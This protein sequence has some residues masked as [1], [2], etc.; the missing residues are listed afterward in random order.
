MKTLRRL[1]LTLSFALVAVF[2]S[3]TAVSCDDDDDTNN[4]NNINNINNTNNPTPASL[5]VIHLS[6]DAPGVDIYV[7]GESQVVTDLMFQ[8][9]TSF[10]EVDEGT[11]DFN[12]TATQTPVDQSVLDIEGVMLMGGSAYTVAAYDALSDI[13]AMLLTEDWSE[14]GAG[15]IRVRAIH[16]AG[17]V[18]E[19][20]IWE[21]SDPEN[22]IELYPNIGFGDVGDYMDLPAG[23]YTLGIDVDND[24]VPDVK[25]EIPALPA[26]T[27]ANI[28]AV[29]EMEEVYLV[30]QFEDHTTTVIEPS[31]MAGPAH[32][33][34]LHLSPDAPSVDVFVDGG[35]AFENIPFENG[36][37]YVDLDE[38]TYTFDVSETGSAVEDSVLTI[39][40]LSLNA[41]LY[42]TAVAY[43][44]LSMIAPMALIDD[45][46]G[47]EAGNIRFRA[48]HTAESFGQVDIWEV[49]DSENPMLLYEDVNFGDA[50]G[51]WDL[52]AQA[53][54]LG[55]D[56]DNDMIP[57]AVWNIPALPEG[58]VANVFAVN[59]DMGNIFLLAQFMDGTTVHIDPVM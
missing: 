2:F 38:G 3:L 24:M 21:I 40:D 29:Y 37:E 39:P 51:Y 35:L 44:V 43:D 55:F 9:S 11:Y 31:P 57:D 18:G 46:E 20:D 25:Y 5:R 10:L 27:I 58:T 22:P 30:V 48:I 4:A 16:A 7:N 59:D 47:L 15:D 6:P 50:G 41:D 53:Y 36:T 13:K 49:S 26:G 19:V 52:P 33:R 23:A 17:M 12:V 34:V 42:Y 54:T 56:V 32:I 45:Y 28:F 1:S 8:E 14:L